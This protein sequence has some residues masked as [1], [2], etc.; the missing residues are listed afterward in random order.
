MLSEYSAQMEGQMQKRLQSIVVA[1]LFSMPLTAFAIERPELPSSAKKLSEKEIV[2]LMGGVPLTYKEYMAGYLYTGTIVI[3]FQNN[4][5]DEAYECYGAA[6]C[7]ISGKA[8]IKDDMYCHKA[9][10]EMEICTFIYLDGSL[11]RRG[12]RRE[13]LCDRQETVGG[14]MSN[15]TSGRDGLPLPSRLLAFTLAVTYAASPSRNAI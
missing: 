2:E 11:L 14:E 3:D 8:W 12:N 9:S 1:L 5:F 4:K 7:P 6:P 15:E 13:G 10:F